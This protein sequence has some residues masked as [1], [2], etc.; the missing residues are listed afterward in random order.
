MKNTSFQV[1]PGFMFLLFLAFIF[2]CKKE[3]DPAPQSQPIDSSSGNGDTVILTQ[4]RTPGYLNNL[5]NW[6]DFYLNAYPDARALDVAEDDDKFAYSYKLN[7]GNWYASL[8]L[9]GFG[10]TI[11][12]T[13][14]IRKITLKVRRFKQGE[15]TI[16]D[17]FL[18][19]MQQNNCDNGVCRYGVEWTDLDTYPGKTYPDTETEYVFSQSGEGNDGGY[20]HDQFYRWTPASINYL[21][22]GVR[23][24]VAQLIGQG[25]LTV[26]YD[27]VELTVEY[28]LE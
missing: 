6:Q 3:N 19:L 22:F 21:R 24:D 9:Q 15:A 23:I 17:Y 25:D 27:L 20:N 18:T 26:F 28:S 10:F 12:D 5:N 8:S 14:T 16:G 1:I 11:P 13:A 7:S 4:T 2:G